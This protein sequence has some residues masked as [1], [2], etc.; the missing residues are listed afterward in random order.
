MTNG[1]ARR[2]HSGIVAV[3]NFLCSAMFFQQQSFANAKRLLTY[4]RPLTKDM[5]GNTINKWSKEQ[6]TGPTSPGRPGVA[7]T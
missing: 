3:D 7:V 2:G 1:A 6:R 4:T 5:V